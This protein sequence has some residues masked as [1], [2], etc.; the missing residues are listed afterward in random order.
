MLHKLYHDHLRKGHP[1]VEGLKEG[2]SVQAGDVIGYLGMTGY[3]SNEDANNIKIPHLHFGLQII[4]D[5]AQKDGINQI[6][7]D[8]YNIV[9]LLEKNRMPV[10]K[11]ADGKDWQRSRRINNIVTD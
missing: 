6:W 8:V 3:S 4:F 7:I 9:K 5:E 2:D 10:E 11:N 1:F